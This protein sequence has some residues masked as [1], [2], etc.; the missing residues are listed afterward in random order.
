MIQHKFHEQGDFGSLHQ[1]RIDS[2]AIEVV[3][4]FWGKGWIGLSI[5]DFGK[6]DYVLN[7]LVDP[8]EEKRKES[9]IK[10]VEDYLS[11]ELCI[12]LKISK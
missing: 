2:K 1:I 8:K 7:E 10:Q 6:D 11:S 9:L 5:Y 4:D 3:I 12:N